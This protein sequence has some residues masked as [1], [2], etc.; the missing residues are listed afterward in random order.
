MAVFTV[1]AGKQHANLQAFITARAATTGVVDA[2]CYGTISTLGTSIGSWA[3]SSTRIYAHPSCRFKGTVKA[4][5]C[6]H[7]GGL[8][9]SGFAGTG[10]FTLDGIR[11]AGGIFDLFPAATCSLSI[12]NCCFDADVAPA[13]FISAS[14]ITV[15]LVFANN[16][17]MLSGDLGVDGSVNGPTL[18]ATFVYNYIGGQWDWQE[19]GTT[20]IHN[21]TIKNNAILQTVQAAIVRGTKT[22][23]HNLTADG[24]AD[25]VLGGTNNII[26]TALSSI[27]KS[28][29][30]DF[31]LLNGK[32]A[33]AFAG[34]PVSTVVDDMAGNSRPKNNPCIGPWEFP[35]LERKMMARMPIG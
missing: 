30:T 23:S 11:F 18:N 31:R 35:P 15:T 27:V 26:N 8:D 1:G 32:V 16:V 6:I 4:N 14:G 28:T 13:I 21:L 25:S 24:S 22:A 2:E 3:A 33:A 5:S 17:V 19:T 29:T 12:V 10:N 9:M 7:S 34:T 20:S